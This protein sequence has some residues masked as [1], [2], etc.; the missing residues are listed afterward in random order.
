MT[1][2]EANKAGINILKECCETAWLD[3]SVILGYVLNKER[4]YLIAHS[5]EKLT[6]DELTEYL[7]LINRR[8]S[9]VP[10]QYIT[11]RQEFMSLNFFVNE[12][13]LIPR[14]DTE[15]IVEEILRYISKVPKEKIIKLLD[16]GTGSGCIALSIAKYTNNTKIKAIDISEEAL[17]VAKKNACTLGL[18]DK[19]EFIFSD[20][21][22]NIGQESF[23]I[24][25]SNPPYIPSGIIESLQVEVRK[26]E[27]WL[28]LDGGEDGLDYYRRII[29]EGIDILK[30]GGLLIFEIG[31]D[32]AEAVRLIISDFKEYYGYEIIKDLANRD[33]CITV[34]RNI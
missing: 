26:N 10:T 4:W 18:E 5:E 21:F 22:D 14:S 7:K 17:K 6:Q 28:A 33:R 23:D 20:L 27:P 31:Y 30:L 24:I 32:Q 13:V 15:V 16:V 1:I 29:A 19:V 34:F 8:L 2:D 9:G 12:S 25:V 11:G 3:A